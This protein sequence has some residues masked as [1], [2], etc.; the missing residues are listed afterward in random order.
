M[1]RAPDSLCEVK[2]ALSNPSV[3][4]Y[5]NFSNQ[6]ELETDASLS[7][8]GAVLTQWDEN[9]HRRVTTFSSHSLCLNEKAIQNY[10]SER[11]ELLL[12]KCNAWEIVQLLIKVMFYCAHQQWSISLYKREQPWWHSKFWLSKLALYNFDIKYQRGKTKVV[13]DNLFCYDPNPGFSLVF[14]LFGKERTGLKV[15]RELRRKM[16]RNTVC[17]GYWIR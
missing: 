11:L 14:H 2:Y 7:G 10:S 1:E 6:F 16:M 5:P 17:Q 15:E 9:G 3:L 8:L 12:L 4:A 13:A